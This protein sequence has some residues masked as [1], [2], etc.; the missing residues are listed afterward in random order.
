MLTQRDIPSKGKKGTW[1][2][3]DYILMNERKWYLMEHEEYGT[4][5]AYVILSEDGAVV[6]N[7]YYNGLDAEAREKIQTFMKQQE[8]KEQNRKQRQMQSQTQPNRTGTATATEEKR[9]RAGKLAEGH[10][11]RRISSQCRDGRR[12]QLQHDRW[13]DEMS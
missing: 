2:V 10:G 7:D 13:T 8:A 9:T 12:S 3:I 6:M 11:Q 5:A 1:Q 4:R